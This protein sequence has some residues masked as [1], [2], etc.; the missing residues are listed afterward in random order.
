MS[1]TPP[2]WRSQRRRPDPRL[3]H[4]D[5][6]R[7]QPR[8]RGPRRR[9][10][11]PRA[12][13]VVPATRQ[14]TDGHHVACVHTGA[15]KPRRHHPHRTTTVPTTSCASSPSASGPHPPPAPRRSTSLICRVPHRVSSPRQGHRS[16][17]TP[18]PRH[19]RARR[20]PPRRLIE[21]GPAPKLTRWRAHRCAS[22]LGRPRPA[23]AHP[24][25]G[26]GTHPR[27]VGS[28]PQ[29]GAMPP[30]PARPAG[31]PNRVREQRAIGS[32]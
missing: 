6:R 25:A 24:R 20:R 26:V 23:G 15:G 14:L 29:P 30:P 1:R 2:G 5:R 32:G 8:H 17:R 3:A 11:H 19:R 27:K 12:P 10:H 9:D 18:H 22:H 16:W 13:G 21:P 28:Y 31:T 4:G 7:D